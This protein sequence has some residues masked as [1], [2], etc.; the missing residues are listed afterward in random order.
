MFMRMYISKTRHAHGDS[1]H[2]D[3]VLLLNGWDNDYQ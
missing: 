3:V 1:A 2:V